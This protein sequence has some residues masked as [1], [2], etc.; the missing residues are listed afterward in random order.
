MQLMGDSRSWVQHGAGAARG[1]QHPAT[2]RVSATRGRQRNASLGRI[3]R[4][5]S[6]SAAEHPRRAPPGQSR[7]RQHRG[8][9]VE[10]DLGRRAV[11]AP[12]HALR[13][14]RGDAR[15]EARVRTRPADVCTACERRSAGVPTRFH[16]Q[17][18]LT[19][20]GP[21]F[22]L[23]AMARCAGGLATTA[24]GASWARR[25]PRWRWLLGPRPCSSRWRPSTA[26]RASRKGA[27]GRGSC[28]VSW[29]RRSPASHHARPRGPGLSS[30][31]RAPQTRQRVMVRMV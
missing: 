5:R 17:A 21:F 23:G 12:R 13:H 31:R 1:H 28:R 6:C 18:T 8:V 25:P 15:H 2:L 14:G 19:F 10:R 20:P 7:R 3:R 29:S 11:W 26:P 16:S 9:G 30:E 4:G 22:L 27:A 24:A